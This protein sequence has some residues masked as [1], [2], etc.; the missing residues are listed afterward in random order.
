MSLLEAEKF[1]PV[2]IVID[3]CFFINIVLPGSNYYFLA[4]GKIIL[5]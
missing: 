5:F 3:F 1:F 4:F 2:G